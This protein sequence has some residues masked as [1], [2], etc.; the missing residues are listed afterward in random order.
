MEKVPNANEIDT[1]LFNEFMKM[2]S[3]DLAMTRYIA[4][5]V[6]KVRSRNLEKTP[7]TKR[8]NYLRDQRDPK[9]QVGKLPLDRS[10]DA[11]ELSK[12]FEELEAAFNQYEIV[13]H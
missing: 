8:S 3:G 1:T 5:D 11:R 10:K 9:R 2:L 13:T 6:K 4:Q 12:R 7:K